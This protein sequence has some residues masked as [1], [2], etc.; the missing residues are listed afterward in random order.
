MYDAL[1]FTRDFFHVGH[2]RLS[3]HP[4]LLQLLPPQKITQ[5]ASGPRSPCHPFCGCLS[6]PPLPHAQLRATSLCPPT[7]A[8][9]FF[10]WRTMTLNFK[11]KAGTGHLC[12]TRGHHEN[13][14]RCLASTFND[15]FPNKRVGKLVTKWRNEE[16]NCI[17]GSIYRR[18]LSQRD[19][20][21][22]RPQD[23]WAVWLRAVDLSERN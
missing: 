11:L 21:E 19:K 22:K 3:P 9:T 14:S 13:K 6:C 7:V 12:I 10:L 5:Q 15:S 20:E 18:L 2:S 4:H 17:Q 8:G 1:A 23:G 16:K